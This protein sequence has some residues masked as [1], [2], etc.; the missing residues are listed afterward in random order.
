MWQEIPPN[1]GP[2]DP[3]GFLVKSSIETTNR[4]PNMRVSPVLGVPGGTWCGS[5]GWFRCRSWAY[6]LPGTQQSHLE[7]SKVMGVIPESS[8][9]L[10]HDLVLKP[11][12]TFGSSIFRNL[13]LD[14]WFR[15]HHVNVSLFKH[16]LPIFGHTNRRRSKNIQS[17]KNLSWVS[18][19]SL[20]WFFATPAMR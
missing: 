8:K 16:L 20:Q 19:S 9:S 17:K 2:E 14:Q 12:V 7:L 4:Y 10:D 3:Y 13:H 15:E 11:M 5:Q 1:W 6:L 18:L